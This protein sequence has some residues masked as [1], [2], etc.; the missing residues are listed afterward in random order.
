MVVDNERLWAIHR[1]DVYSADGRRRL[2]IVGGS[3]A[4]LGLV[5]KELENTFPE[6]KVKQLAIDGTPA[7]AIVKDLCEDVKFD[8]VIIWSATVPTMFPSADSGRRDVVYTE[9][10]RTAFRGAGYINDNLN[11]RIEAALQSSFV[12]LSPDMVLRRQIEECFCPETNYIRMYYSRVR[13]ARYHQ[14]MSPERLMN[15][16]AERLRRRS[17]THLKVDWQDFGNLLSQDLGPKADAL[18]RRGGKLNILR[19]PTTDE[20]WRMDEEDVPKAL[21]WDLITAR[22]GIAS[23]H[24]KDYPELSSFD[25]PDTSHLDWIDASNFTRSF[26]SILKGYLE[27]ETTQNKAKISQ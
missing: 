26:A 5:P 12:V 19:M 6:Y 22:S 10:Y 14:V 15:H 17:L 21:Y 3:R 20:H 1:D 7:Y 11:C 4:Q 16:R 9:F 18:A 23:I 2:V 25:C 27:T 13:A 24:F 8:G